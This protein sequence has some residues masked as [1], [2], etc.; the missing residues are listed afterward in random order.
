MLKI[1]V[2]ENG[3][4][5][6]HVKRGGKTGRA[7]K[8][9]QSLL[10]AVD[11]RRQSRWQSGFFR[12]HDTLRSFADPLNA[13]AASMNALSCAVTLPFTVEAS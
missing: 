9:V 6:R 13:F 4:L 8:E 10:T 11:G 12:V 1:P 3:G 5:Q 2:L 7:A